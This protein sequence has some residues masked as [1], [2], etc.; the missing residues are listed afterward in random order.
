MKRNISKRSVF[1]DAYF[2]HKGMGSKQSKQVAN[3]ILRLEYSTVHKGFI[4]DVIK[5]GA[6]V[7]ITYGYDDD[8]YSFIVNTKEYA[9]TNVVIENNIKYNLKKD[10][11]TGYYYDGVWYMH[12]EWAPEIIN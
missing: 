6:K 4:M 7:K 2:L 9:P 1:Y 5:H 8:I 11:Y 3:N 12:S 10:R